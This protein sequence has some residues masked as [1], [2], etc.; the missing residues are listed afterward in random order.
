MDIVERLRT[1]NTPFGWTELADKAADE[2]E[3][4][5]KS[6]VEDVGKILGQVK[7]NKAIIDDATDRLDRA[8]L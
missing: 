1:R 7:E 2:I 6:W 3:R 4:L 8:G 5:R